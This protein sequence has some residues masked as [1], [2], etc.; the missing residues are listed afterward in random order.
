MTHSRLYLDYNATS[1]LSPSVKNWLKSGDF[2]F[3]NPSSQHSSGKAAR[4]VVNQTRAS[5][6][7]LFKK[8]ENGHKLFFH[9]GATEAF[10]SFLYSFSEWARLEGRKLLFCFSKLDHPCVTAL[11]HKF[12][13][14]HVSSYQLKVDTDLGYAHQENYRFISDK[15]ADDPELLILYHHLWVHNET[16]FVYP[17]EELELF[18]SIPDL[19]LHVDAVQA[20]GKIADWRELTTGDIF[21]FSAHKF[22]AIKGI[23][24]SLVA[25]SIRFF[26]LLTG[27]G[28]QS[29]FRSGTENAMACKSIQLALDDLSTVDVTATGVF[30][31]ELENFLGLELQGMGEVVTHASLKRNSNTIYFFLNEL[32]SDV[33]LALFD[34]HGLEISAGSACSSGT[35]KDSVLLLQK[36]LKHVAKNGL[37]LSLGFQVSPS[38]K[39]LLY[40]QLGLILGKLKPLHKA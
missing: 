38:D 8:N 39:A 30:R 33:A 2:N 13:G 25:N 24:F 18:K 5:I 31:A 35:A 4:K 21:S 26:P 10:A 17:L 22:G 28:Q 7:S 1:P 12:F 16:G 20:P 36:G 3:A 40:Q 32:P 14:D 19:Y 23:G 27:G 29:G 15:K 9:S 11:D 37:R 6:F 34:L